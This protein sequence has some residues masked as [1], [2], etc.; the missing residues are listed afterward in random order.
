MPCQAVSG[1][2]VLSFGPSVTPLRTSS[3]SSPDSYFISAFSS[4]HSPT[5]SALT[6][7]TGH[8]LTPQKQGLDKTLRSQRIKELDA[9]GSQRAFLQPL[10]QLRAGVVCPKFPCSRTPLESLCGFFLKTTEIAFAD[11]APLLPPP[12]SS[13]QNI[14][15]PMI[16]GRSA[17]DCSHLTKMEGDAAWLSGLVWKRPT[18]LQTDQISDPRRT[19]G[20]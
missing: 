17:E 8:G 9:C 1:R 18:D 3:F 5:L 19:S 4:E 15:I 10:H 20:V 12:Q 14:L 6:E 7:K 16:L 2:E 13:T 11:V